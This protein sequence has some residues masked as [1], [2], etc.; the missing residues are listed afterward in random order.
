MGVTKAAKE[1][2]SR[3][4]AS[5]A[6]YLLDKDKNSWTWDDLKA[7]WVKHCQQQADYTGQFSLGLRQLIAFKVVKYKKREAVYVLT[8]QTSKTKL[9]KWRDARPAEKA[10]LVGNRPY[11][12]PTTFKRALEVWSLPSHFAKLKSLNPY[13]M[14][15]EVSA[16]LERRGTL[17]LTTRQVSEAGGLFQL[18]DMNMK[19]SKKQLDHW[20]ETF[21]DLLYTEELQMAFDIAVYDQDVKEK[22]KVIRKAGESGNEPI[23]HRLWVPGLAEKRP[24]VLRGDRVLVID[25]AYIRFRAYA[26]RVG[27]DYVDLSFHKSFQ[28]RPPFKVQFFFSRT[29]LKLMHRALDDTASR[30]QSLYSDRRPT[31]QRGGVA[32]QIGVG[33]VQLNQPQ[34]GFVQAVVRGRQIYSC[35]LTQEDLELA[36]QLRGPSSEP[37]D[38]RLKNL[39][40][41]ELF[42]QTDEML[43]RRDCITLR[44]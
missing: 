33:A 32:R 22:L 28:N 5:F 1:R 12:P 30:I 4:A 3:L 25:S 38:R 34:Q 41:R 13:Q 19:L 14:K 15:Q 6:A 17:S 18:E 27:L 35:N 40:K 44:F 26:H 31:Q 2:V 24:S 8:L 11:T 29:P 9:Q 20:A 39:P 7:E 16:L 10:G 21:H 43:G 42:H 36:G 37:R 23:L